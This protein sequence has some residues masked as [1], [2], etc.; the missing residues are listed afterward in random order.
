ME[1]SQEINPLK[2]IIDLEKSI[3]SFYIFQ[4][5][6]SFITEKNKLNLIIHNKKYQASFGYD[7]EYYR[8]MSGKYKIMGNNGKGKEYEQEADI[9]LFEGEYLNGKGIEYFYNENKIKFE[10]EYLNGKKIKGKKYDLYGNIIL[11]FEGNGKGKEFIDKGK[12]IFE[13]EYLNGKRW[14]GKWYNPDGK[15]EF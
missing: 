7:L 1:V 15:E 5:I 4:Y 3:K 8:K 13:G 9:L 6:F 12:I 10:G 14:N 2:E 11:V